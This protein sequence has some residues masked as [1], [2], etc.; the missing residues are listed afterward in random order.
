MKD[1]ETFL[2]V[3]GGRPPFVPVG[4][5]E[6]VDFFLLRHPSR[7]PSSYFSRFFFLFFLYSLDLRVLLSYPSARACKSLISNFSSPPPVTVLCSPLRPNL[8]YIYSPFSRF[9]LPYALPSLVFSLFLLY[10]AP[11]R[12]H[13]ANI[14]R[15]EH[16]SVS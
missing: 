2:M 11:P 1:G 6:I 3:G 10:V 14:K 5:V 4:S 9:N 7:L 13:L 12:F 8:S 16:T 15:A